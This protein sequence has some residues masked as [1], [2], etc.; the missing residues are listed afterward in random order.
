MIRE[1]LGLIFAPVFHKLVVWGTFF[2]AFHNTIEIRPLLQ[3]IHF[4][5]C[6][7]FLF[8]FVYAGRDFPVGKCCLLHHPAS[9][10][11]VANHQEQNSDYPV[12]LFVKQEEKFPYKAKL[13]PTPFLD[14]F[15]WETQSSS[16][17]FEICRKG[18]PGTGLSLAMMVASQHYF[19]EEKEQ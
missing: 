2:L 11:V 13:L 9:H 4:S 19:G 10:L 17:H 14:D 8:D 18:W 1:Q 12:Y 7:L 3:F 15:E 5:C 16:N 6:E